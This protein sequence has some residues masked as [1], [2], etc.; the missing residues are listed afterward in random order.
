MSLAGKVS[1]GRYGD[2]LLTKQNAE[3]AEME[4]NSMK[5]M[6]RFLTAAVLCVALAATMVP[7][8]FAAADSNY[9]KCMAEIQEQRTIQSQAHQTAQILRAQGHSE[10]NAYI[11]AAK[12]TW[13]EAAKMIKGYQKLSQYSD[14]DI[15][16]LT[17]TVYYEA[18]N[19][20][21]QLRQYVAQVAL[22]RVADRR[23]PNTVKGVI[24]QA[25]QYST[26]YASAQTAQMLQNKDAKNGT[27]TYAVCENSVKQAMMGMSGMPGNV[28][29]QANFTQGKGVWK[30]VN[31]SSKWFSSTSYF[32]YG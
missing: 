8:A 24:T 32:C 13:T 31:Y 3:A 27:Y 17:T 29:Y 9:N 16:I 22:N 19:T 28:I 30:T 21:E 11:Q 15:R 2:F 18:G 10:S 7:M 1:I 12:S 20:T 23:F 26:K 6:R 25:G 4:I 5:K 14:E